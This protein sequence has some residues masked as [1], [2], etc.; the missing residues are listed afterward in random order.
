MQQKICKIGMICF[1][2]LVLTEDF[3][4]VQKRTFFNNMLYVLN[5]RLTK[6]ETYS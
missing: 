2:K 6:G 1:A 4:V 3:C 5:V